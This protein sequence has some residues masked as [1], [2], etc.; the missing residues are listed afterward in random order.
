MQWCGMQIWK[1]IS[2]KYVHAITGFVMSWKLEIAISQAVNYTRFNGPQINF[3]LL[4]TRLF[5]ISS[6]APAQRS[7]SSKRVCARAWSAPSPLLSSSASCSSRPI[8]CCGAAWNR[9]R[10]QHWPPTQGCLTA[11]SS[12]GAKSNSEDK[13]RR[14]LD[15]RRVIADSTGGFPLEVRVGFRGQPDLT[16]VCMF[17]NT[18]HSS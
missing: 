10:F 1:Q 2:Y 7:K 13:G 6:Q 14:P 18:Y 3:Y 5:F 11:N 4:P 16:Y 15:C 17:R 12:D 9:W 8:R